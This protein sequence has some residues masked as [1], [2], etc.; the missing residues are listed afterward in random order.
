VIFIPNYQIDAKVSTMKEVFE[1][2]LMKILNTSAP[3]L[4]AV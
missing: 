4:N 1:S 3:L 2:M